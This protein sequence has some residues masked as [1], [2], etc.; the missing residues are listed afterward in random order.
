MKYTPYT[1]LAAFAATTLAAS[2]ANLAQGG[3]IDSA[4]HVDTGDYWQSVNMTTTF[5]DRGIKILGADQATIIQQGPGTSTLAFTSSLFDSNE[6]S[7]N[8][9]SFYI[10]DGAG[11]KGI[12]TIN[13]GGG[14]N[15]IGLT[16][17]VIGSNGGT[18]TLNINDDGMVYLNSLDI[19]NGTVNFV[20]NST[21]SFWV[22]NWG[23][24]DYQQC[25]SNGKLTY[26]GQN[27][28]SF[29]DHFEFI[30][31]HGGRYIRAVVPVPEPCTSTLFGIAGLALLLRRHK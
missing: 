3:N 13:S 22:G 4:I 9:T 15:G 6:A 26:N 28:G 30:D 27:N 1:T 31:D 7:G 25:W 5:T 16:D 29:N 19:Q 11:A 14:F 12:V 2:A 24:S 18:G 10:G 21:G 23:D 20:E 8:G 17:F